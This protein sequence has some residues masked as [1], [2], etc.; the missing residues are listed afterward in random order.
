MADQTIAHR[1]I[2]QAI[3]AAGLTI[4]EIST[5]TGLD[6]G[7]VAD[8]LNG[9]RR[10]RRT[11]VRLIE[12]AIPGWE[13]GRF[14]AILDGADQDPAHESDSSGV[15]LSVPP[16]AVEGF[17]PIE[18]EELISDAKAHA[19]ARAAEIRARLNRGE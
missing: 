4:R 18:L 1:A 9:K 14:Q 13:P 8:F 5:T 2:W 19:L 15:L 6:Y 16:E 3:D 11:S 17:T 10:P 12:E 7:T